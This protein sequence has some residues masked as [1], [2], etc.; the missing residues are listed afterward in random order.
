MK[1]ASKHK[2][3][4]DTKDYSPLDKITIQT[5]NPLLFSLSLLIA[6]DKISNDT[7]IEDGI[8]LIESFL[9]EYSNTHAFG[10]ISQKDARQ[11]AVRAI[12]IQASGKN[13][14]KRVLSTDGSETSLDLT[15]FGDE[16]N[17]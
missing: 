5:I 1:K 13:N 7:D 9:I 12:S 11:F 3:R 17:S 10:I 14:I 8:S 15:V 16:A 2:F 4:I 6:K